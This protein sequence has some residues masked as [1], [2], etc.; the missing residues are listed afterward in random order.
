MSEET[1]QEFSTRVQSLLDDHSDKIPEQLYIELSNLLKRE[2]Q[3]EN[4]QKQRVIS[5]ELLDDIAEKT[6]FHCVQDIFN[7]LIEYKP[8]IESVIDLLELDEPYLLI[9]EIRRRRID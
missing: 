3:N 1:K 9:E 2:H 8:A 4:L 7:F 6:Q 5:L